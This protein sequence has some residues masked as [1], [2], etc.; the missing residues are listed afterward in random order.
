MKLNTIKTLLRPTWEL[1]KQFVPSGKTRYFKD[2]DKNPCYWLIKYLKRKLL[3]SLVLPII[4]R[5][6]EL[7]R[8]ETKH[9]RIL[10]INFAAPSLGDSLMDLASRVLLEQKYVVLFT[11]KK[12][13]DLFTPDIFFSEIHTS[14]AS[15]RNTAKIAPFDLVIC[16]SYSPR[17]MF[18]KVMVSPWVDFV[19][20]YRF[21]NGFEVHRT[22]FSFARMEELTGKTN[23]RPLRPIIGEPNKDLEVIPG[24]ICVA[25][26]GEWGFRTYEHWMVV[27]SYLLERGY[28]ITLVGSENGIDAASQIRRIMPQIRCTVARLTL[29]EVIEELKTAQMFI[30]ADG[31]LWHIATAIPLP[32][33][34]L[35]ADC[36]LYNQDGERVT[37]ETKDIVCEPIYDE[38]SVSNIPPDKVIESFERLSARVGNIE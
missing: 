34:V 38:S 24:K 13:A 16:D 12:N 14:I 6:T 29:P 20:L 37:R 28:S 7:A 1:P 35:F 22:L 27:T 25:V 2:L 17:V 19:G 9:K 10:W 15:V 11:N 36:Q 31:G 23:I 33:V 3:F 30:G 5:G 21:L 4:G 26:G 18:R 32:S 8:I